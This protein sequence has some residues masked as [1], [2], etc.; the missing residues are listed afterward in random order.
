MVLR[1]SLSV[2]EAE[3]RLWYLSQW[4]YAINRRS[5]ADFKHH[6]PQHLTGAQQIQCFIDLFQGQGIGHDRLRFSRC[7]QIHNVDQILLA[8][9][10]RSDDLELI[11]CQALA[12]EGILVGGVADNHDSAAVA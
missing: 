8:S 1:F 7:D 12:A 3:W 2:D 5:R 10:A 11:L 6:S 9:A 4:T